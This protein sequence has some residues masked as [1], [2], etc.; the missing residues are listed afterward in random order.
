MKK[1]INRAQTI[2]IKKS[3]TGRTYYGCENNP[4]CD[5]MTWDIPIADICPKCGAKLFRTKGR[6]NKI[7]CRA[8]NCG[9]KKEGNNE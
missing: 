7:I 1:C 4:T 5:F 9:Y 2:L 6:K 3:K 8:E